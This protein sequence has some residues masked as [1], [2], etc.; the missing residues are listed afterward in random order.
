MGGGGKQGLWTLAVLSLLLPACRGQGALIGAALTVSRFCGP[1]SS[2]LL[3]GLNRAT[4]ATPIL[5]PSPLWP[6]LQVSLAAENFQ[7]PQS[8]LQEHID[9]KGAEV[10][11]PARC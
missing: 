4:T 7:V 6:T 11:K 2:S 3:P 9:H 10:L 1:A 5:P 8:D